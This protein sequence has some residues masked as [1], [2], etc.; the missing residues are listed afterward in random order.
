MSQSVSYILVF[1]KALLLLRNVFYLNQPYNDVS[2][3]YG[4]IFLYLGKEK[5]STAKL[6]G[7]F[8]MVAVRK[9]FKTFKKE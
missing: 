6:T 3:L 2:S 8:V 1:C 9:H 4:N 7:P 5:L